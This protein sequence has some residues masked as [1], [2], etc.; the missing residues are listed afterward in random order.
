MKN[1][2]QQNEKEKTLVKFTSLSKLREEIDE[3]E[4]QINDK[5]RQQLILAEERAE[6]RDLYSW[7]APERPFSN[8]STRWYIVVG[9]ISIITIILAILTYTLLLVVAVIAT[10]TLLYAMST[11]PPVIFEYTITNKGLKINKRLFLWSQIPKFWITER[12]K[13]I[14]IN[15]ELF[16]QNQKN[17]TILEGEGDIRIIA[18]E[19]VKYIDYLSPREVAND[20]IMTLTGWRHRSISD[21]MTTEATS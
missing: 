8:R 15:F 3:L 16:D 13:D 7:R 1:N 9:T 19:L 20:I 17:L 18:K 5:K 12:G 6:I 10:L 14:F 4:K 11:V 21:F 2:S